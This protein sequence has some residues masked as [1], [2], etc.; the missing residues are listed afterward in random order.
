MKNADCLSRRRFMKIGASMVLATSAPPVQ[1]KVRFKRKSPSS[2]DLVEVGLLTANGGHSKGIWTRQYNPPE[3]EIRRAGM[4]LTKIWTL[5][6]ET[7]DFYR[8]TY[9]VDRVKSLDSMVGKVDGVLVDDFYGVAYN[10]KMARPYLESGVPTFVNRP[11]ADSMEKVR[12]MLD[13]SEK[14][15]APIMTASS[16]EHVKEVHSIRANIDLNTVTGYDAWNSCSDFYSHGLHG[17]WWAYAALGGGIA[18]VALKTDDWRKSAGSVTHAVYDDR[19]AG[20]FIGKINEG[21]MPDVGRSN[22]AMTIR[23]GNRTF[24]HYWADQ[25]SR[26]LFLWVPMLQRVQWMFETGGMYQTRDE[27]AEKCALFIGA[28]HSHLERDG[29]LVDLDSLPEDWAIGSPHGIG[30]ATETDALYASYFGKEEGALK[31][32]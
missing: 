26:D 23:P 30:A 12:A 17:L 6:D 11:F 21:Q 28:F 1:A 5:R 19:G 32:E 10:H 27:I 14:G 7:A 18:S 22:C 15:G 3:G 20:P 24:I 9:G 25:W 8:E 2:L 31:P 4:V 13:W 29:G 16:F